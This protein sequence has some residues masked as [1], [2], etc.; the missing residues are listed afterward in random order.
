MA[1]VS[2]PFGFSKFPLLY[3]FLPG[4]QWGG[5]A[6]VRF[7]EQQYRFDAFDIAYYIL[8]INECDNSMETLNEVVTISYS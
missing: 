5:M 7:L 2:F 8:K 3:I 6:I 4:L 1:T